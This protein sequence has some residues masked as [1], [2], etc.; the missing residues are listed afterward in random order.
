MDLLHSTR[1]VRLKMYDRELQIGA[2][3]EK[4]RFQTLVEWRFQ[5]RV[6]RLQRQKMS[7]HFITHAASWYK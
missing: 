7:L 1:N 6:V 2:Q 4:I 5:A 3:W